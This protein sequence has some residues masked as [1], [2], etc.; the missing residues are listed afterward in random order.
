MAIVSRPIH[1][2]ERIKNKPFTGWV[3]PRCVSKVGESPIKS[4][5]TKMTTTKKLTSNMDGRIRKLEVAYA[6]GYY[7]ISDL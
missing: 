4:D 3:G 1:H 6:V 7:E 2:L 5:H